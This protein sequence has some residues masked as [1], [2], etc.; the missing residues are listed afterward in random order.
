MLFRSRGK[1]GRVFGNQMNLMTMLKG[2]PL[3]YNK[4]MQ[5]D[6]Q[7]IFDS[8]LTVRLCLQSMTPMLSTMKV[9]KDRMRNAANKGFI[10]ATD[11]ADYLVRKGMPFRDA[12]AVTGE[13]VR[14]CIEKNQTLDSLPLNEYQTIHT[15][16][17]TDIYE[18]ID[19]NACV[20]KRNVE[21]G[22][23]PVAVRNQMKRLKDELQELLNPD[24]KGE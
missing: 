2:L 8:V 7:A 4:D 3:C 5:E 24:G 19:L 9:D 12:Y 22:P 6:K 16:F 14:S 18:S 21:G 15:A 20:E 10:N 13:L 17:E 11:C 1:T 23:A